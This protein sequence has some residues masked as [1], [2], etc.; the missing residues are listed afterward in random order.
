MAEE[1]IIRILLPY[2]EITNGFSVALSKR[3]N[4]FVTEQ[5]YNCREIFHEDFPTTDN[6]IF[7]CQLTKKTE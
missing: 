3:N 6:L 4:F 5:F 1:E 7:V 2:K